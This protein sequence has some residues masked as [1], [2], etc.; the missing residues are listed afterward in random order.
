MPGEASY[1]NKKYLLTP[2]SLLALLGSSETRPPRETQRPGRGESYSGKLAKDLLVEMFRGNLR[3]APTKR[4]CP[5]V[6][7]V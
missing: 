2:Q 5:P 3:A 6:L 4:Q 7:S 1:S